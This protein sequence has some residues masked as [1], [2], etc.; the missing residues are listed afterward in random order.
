MMQATIYMKMEDGQTVIWEGVGDDLR[1]C[2]GLAFA[3][4][5]ELTGEQIYDSD[6]E[7]LEV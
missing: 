7:F 3:Y 1:H 5:N 4:A 2:E 6:A